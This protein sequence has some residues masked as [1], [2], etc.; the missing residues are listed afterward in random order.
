MVAIN[1]I[2]FAITYWNG[3]TPFCQ[4]QLRE[5][6][7]KSDAPNGKTDEPGSA[8]PPFLTAYALLIRRIEDRLRAAGLPELAWYDVLWALERAPRGRLRMH[9]LAEKTVVTRSNLTR[10]IDRLEAALL[11]ARDRNC[12]DRRGSFAVLTVSGRAMRRKMWAVY[13]PAIRELFD[14]HLNASQTSE[15]RG[16]FAR[17]I[18]AARDGGG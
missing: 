4:S 13:G 2:A 15:M 10:L 3:Q 9:E 5:A 11:V 12:T 7:V 6:C 17:V 16:I 18:E 8:W 1:M 14:R